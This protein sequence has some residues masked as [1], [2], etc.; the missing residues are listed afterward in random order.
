MPNYVH[1]AVL[2]QEV[3]EYLDPKP[4]KIYIDGTL[5]GGGHSRLILEQLKN[6]GHLYSFDQD[7]EVINRI[8]AEAKSHN[9]W[10]LVHRNFEEIKNYCQENNIKITGGVLLDLGLSS[11]Q[12]DDPNRG[13][14]FDSEAALDMR[15]NPDADLTAAEVI[16]HYQEA[17]IADILY[18]YGEERKSRQ[19]AKLIISKRPFHSCNSLADAIKSFSAKRSD[20]KTFRIHPATKTFQALRIYINR[21]LEVLKNILQELP[22]VMEVDARIVVISFHS[23]EDRIVKHAF[24]RPELQIL[25]KKPLQASETETKDNPRSRSAKLRAAARL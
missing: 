14:N 2:A 12:L 16:N 25:T 13:F 19:L 9:N 7:R 15:L 8:A 3:L 17:A 20:G 18:H 22:E 6:Q 24:K 1:Q 21:E 4:G 11:I 23:L 5:G 10:T